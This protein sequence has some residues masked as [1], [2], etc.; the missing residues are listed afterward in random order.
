MT[1]PRKTPAKPRTRTIQD[2]Q[3]V[4][5]IRLVVLS[6]QR[7]YFRQE[8]YGGKLDEALVQAVLARIAQQEEALVSSAAQEVCELLAQKVEADQGTS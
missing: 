4:L 8:S 6:Q 2:V 5:R 7:L 1:T 3:D